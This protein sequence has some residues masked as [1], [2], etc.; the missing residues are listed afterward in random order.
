VEGD[1]CTIPC[2]RRRLQAPG[3]VF[4]A[5]RGPPHIAIASARRRG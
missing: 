1:G 3:G 2:R 4:R 5:R